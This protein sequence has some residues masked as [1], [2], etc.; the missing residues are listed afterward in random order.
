M[1]EKYLE[2][3]RNTINKNLENLFHKNDIVRFAS[4]IDIKNMFVNKENS[5]LKNHIIVSISSISYEDTCMNSRYYEA[6]G[7]AYIKKLKPLY[8]NIFAFFQSTF[9][10]DDFLEGIK[11]LSEIMNFLHANSFFSSSTIPELTSQKLVDFN[12]N[13]QKDDKEYYQSLKIPY[14]PSFLTKIGPI[15]LYKDLI[16]EKIP[17][18]TTF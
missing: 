3:V 5:P 12:V 17:S 1:I 10:G 13:I 2:L 6:Q 8:I 16:P 9:Y 18:V 7:Q 15:P 4:T 11:Y 14:L